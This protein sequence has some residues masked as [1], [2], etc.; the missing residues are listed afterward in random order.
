[1]GRPFFL[2]WNSTL[3]ANTAY[4]LS[5]NFIYL[6]FKALLNLLAGQSPELERLPFP[7]GSRIRASESKSVERLDYVQAAEAEALVPERCASAEQA[8]QVAIGRA[9][10]RQQH[11]RGNASD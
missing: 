9:W 10:F 11:F 8:L 1:M 7:F 3:Y 4:A 5:V 6:R 2:I